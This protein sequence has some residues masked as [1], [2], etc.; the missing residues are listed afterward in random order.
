LAGSFVGRRAILAQILGADVEPGQASRFFVVSG[1]PGSGKTELL[2][3]LQWRVKR[4]ED[5]PQGTVI[6]V[7]GG[8]YEVIGSRH[9]VQGFDE[10]AELR[11]FKTLLQEAI[12][13]E[14]EGTTDTGLLAEAELV[15]PGLGGRPRARDGVNDSGLIIEQATQAMTRLAGELAR[16]GKRLLLL[17]DDFHL[18]AG[19]PVGDWALRWLTGIRGADIVL[20]HLLV[21]A[22]AGPGPQ[23]PSATIPISL[24]NL[25]CD[26][27]ERYLAAHPGIGP[28]VAD[29]IGPVWQFTVGHPQA[30]VLTADL[31][32]ENPLEAVQD[33]KRLHA[34]EG[35]L[36]RQ[37]DVLVE[38]LF[39]AIGDTELRDALYSLCVTR[40]FDLALLIRLLELDEKHGQ[41]LI[42]QIRQFSFVT[43][44]AGGRFLAISDFVRRIGQ[45][46]HVDWTRGQRIHVLAADYFHG[47]IADEMADDKGWAQAGFHLEDQRFQTFEKDWL[48]HL[49]HLEGRQRGT[50]RLEIARI[51]LDGFWWWGCYVPFPFCDEILAD[52]SATSDDADDHAWS[53]A[54]RTVYQSYPKRGRLEKTPRA[55]WIQLRRYLRYLW[56]Q[57]GF[58]RDSDDPLLRHLRGV[59]DIFLVDALR[60]LNPA[61]TRIDE[62]LDDAVNQLAGR[63]DYDDYMVAWLSYPR[64]ELALQRGQVEQAMELAISGV[65]ENSHLGTDDLI[66]N[67]HRVYADA[68][69]SRR[70][71][72]LALDGYA[73]AVALG[74][75]YQVLTHP[76]DCTIPF[77]QEMIDR[78]LERMVELRA[79]GESAHAVLAASCGRIRAF[80]RPYWDEVGAEPVTDVAGEVLR[81]LDSG[82][83]GDAA[84]LLFPAIA[85]GVDADFKRQAPEW[86]LICR[87]VTAEMADELAQ[88]PGT[89]LPSAAG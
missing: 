37:L 69:W 60:Y 65:R 30:M 40:H 52:W 88:P 11:Q 2:N 58:G 81:A 56:D 38:R 42:D 4:G 48:H 73:R 27:V 63:N 80:F 57:G 39:R 25:D 89:P 74:Y 7:R 66:G 62:Y 75:R 86:E 36:S 51:F 45:A 54:L 76:D 85:P 18:L 72:P 9:S 46:N 15:L 43:E 83:L 24:G 64:S 12:P 59:I 68:L 34:L 70:E 61:D 71:H 41:T 55:Q 1:I 44:S 49:G 53:Q 87:D 22:A 47:L 13:D 14:A 17:V 32:R 6:F 26:D 16:Q 28:D 31:I 78:C 77:Q 19:R 33:I 10:I 67:L 29:I 82:R 8:E 79:D 20:T 5:A 23:W 50:G 3:Q 21:P 35:G 84:T